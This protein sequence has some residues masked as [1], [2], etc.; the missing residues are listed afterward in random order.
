MSNLN[1]LKDKSANDDFLHACGTE[2]WYKYN[3]GMLLTDGIKDFAETCGAFWLIDEIVNSQLIKD[4]KDLEYKCWKLKHIEG[5]SFS[6]TCTDGNENIIYT[7]KIP[8]S[9]FKYN[10]VTIWVEGNVVLLPS[11]H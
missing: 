6:L 8:F 11:E 4:I 3:F 2:R 9:D 1:N 10:S 5:R 7:K